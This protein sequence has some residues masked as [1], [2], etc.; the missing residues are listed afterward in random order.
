MES[1]AA[2][3]RV[4]DLV[5]AATTRIIVNVCSRKNRK[6]YTVSVVKSF[7]MH[8]PYALQYADR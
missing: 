4:T 5:H 7:K 1:R 3:A 2:Q 6:Y 8:F